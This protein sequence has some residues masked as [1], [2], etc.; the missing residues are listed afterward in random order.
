LS[1]HFEEFAIVGLTTIGSTCIG[2]GIDEE[3]GESMSA[4]AL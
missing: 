2:L 3:S 4:G 1:K